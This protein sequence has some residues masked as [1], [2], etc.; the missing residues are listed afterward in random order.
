MKLPAGYN[1]V[2][3]GNIPIRPMVCPEGDCVYNTDTVCDEP[4]I[5]NGNSDAKCFKWL[6]RRILLMLEE[7][8]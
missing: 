4:R 2:C 3:K 7:I 8:E 1:R 6:N 5:N